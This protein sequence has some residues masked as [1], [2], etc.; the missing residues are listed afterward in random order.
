MKKKIELSLSPSSINLYNT[1]Q[2]QFYYDYIIGAEPDTKTIEAYGAGGSAVHV[3]LEEYAKNKSINPL[4]FFSNYWHDKGIQEMSGIMGRKLKFE[5]YEQAVVRGKS[6]LDTVYT[7]PIAEEKIKWKLLETEEFVV[8]VA[9]IIDLKCV[10]DGKKILVDWKTSSKVDKGEGFKLQGRHYTYLEFKKYNYIPDEIIFEYV[11]IDDKKSHSFTKQDL[12]EHEEYLLSLAKE[13]VAKGTDI[14]RYEI[15]E[16]GGIFNPH[17][18]KCEQEKIRRQDKNVIKTTLKN[19]MLIFETLPK[20]LSIAMDEK[21]SYYTPGYNWSELYKKRLWDGKTHLFKNNRLPYG[22]ITDFK[23]LLID[24]NNYFKTD[25]KLEILDMRNEKIVNKTFGTKFKDSNIKLRY[26]QKDAIKAAIDKKVGILYIGTGGGKTLLI[27]EMI[28][29]LDRRTMFIV[30]RIE[31]VRQTKK[32]LKDYLGIEIGEISQGKADTNKKV[33]VACIQTIYS[34]LKRNDE[35]SKKM[36]LYL[37]NVNFGIY[38]EAQN[39]S[40]EGMYGAISK[41]LKNNDYFIGLSGSPW[42]NDGCTLEMNALV[43]KPIYSKPTEELEKEGFLCPTKCFFVN[44]NENQTLLNDMDY[45]EVYDACIVDNNERNKIIVDFVNK[46]SATKKILVLT[47]RIKHAELL[48]R[49]I[50]NAFC[51]TGQTHE[52]ARESMFEEF[53]EKDKV[54]L[55][56][57]TKIFSAGVDIPDLDIIVNASGHKSSVDS[58]QIIGRAKRLSPGKKFGYFIDFYDNVKYLNK[59]SDERIKVLKK[60]KNELKIVD[61]ISEVLIE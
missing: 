58:V 31:L 23:E 18:K 34:I 56:G 52:L 39:L 48:S 57:S 50:K 54:V 38:D 47:K 14:S 6:L 2:L 60:F 7:N 9:G 59:A 36:Q 16:I 19:N 44:T 42:R 25:Y 8:Y 20:K 49:E 17:R 27:T 24:Y 1:S 26:Y 29:A 3:T 41:F 15:G 11:K 13:I 30:N 10:K 46:H 43:G 37:H 51:I 12:I 55:V 33:T 32:V 40:N 22:F 61:K 4:D 45:P 5:V 53:K 35:T 28:K 21:Y